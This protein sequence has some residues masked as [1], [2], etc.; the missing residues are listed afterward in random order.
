MNK[1]IELSAMQ[2][3]VY[4]LIIIQWAV[5]FMFTVGYLHTRYLLILQEGGFWDW[6]IQML[7]AYAFWPFIL[8]MAGAS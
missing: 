7:A 1:R 4:M 6:L 2:F 8:G 3:T 5:G